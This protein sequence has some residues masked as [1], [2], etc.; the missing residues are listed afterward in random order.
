MT[1]FLAA[2]AIACTAPAP[3]VVSAPP[4][5]SEE[6]APRTE[7]TLEGLTITGHGLPAVSEDGTVAVFLAEREESFVGIGMMLGPFTVY[8]LDWITLPS[9]EV[10]HEPIVSIRPHSVSFDASQLNCEGDDFICPQDPER[11]RQMHE[12]ARAEVEANVARANAELARHL[13]RP[14]VP[15]EVDARDED[16]W[17]AASAERCEVRVLIEEEARFCEARADAFRDPASDLAVVRVHCA[18]GGGAGWIEQ[19]ACRFAAAPAVE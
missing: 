8:D 12:E 10:R 11:T 5:A 15:R 19:R 2:L 1:R 14:L 7:L 16:G 3:R 6:P 13:W 9:G 17:Y 18:W 4:I